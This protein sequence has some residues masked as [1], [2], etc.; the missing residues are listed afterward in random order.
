MKT[1]CFVRFGYLSEDPRLQK[2]VGAALDDGWNVHVVCLKE[3]GRSSL[4]SNERLAVHR[5]KLGR[6]R[7]GKA[8]YLLQYARFL[9]GALARVARIAR[10]QPLAV[11]QVLNVPNL[12]V[13]AALPARRR[14]A[15]IVLDMQEPMPELF[16]DRFGGRAGGVVGAILRGEERL[17]AR[18]A[19]DVITVSDLVRDLVEPRCGRTRPLVVVENTP[20]ERFFQW[21]GEP[22]TPKPFLVSCHSSLLPRYGVNVLVEAFTGLRHLQDVRLEIYGDGEERPEL[23]G[24]ARR[25]GLEDVVTFHGKYPLFELAHD[26]GRVHVGVVPLMRTPFTELMSPNK[27]F[28]YVAL[29]KPVIASRLA[30]MQAYFGEAAVRFVEPGDP[31]QLAGAIEELYGDRALRTSLAREAGLRLESVRWA[32]VRERYLDVLRRS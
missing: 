28:E 8:T 5:L 9:V 15:R 27:L 3:D 23:E 22:E 31:G 4:E 16:V 19:D 30:G 21:V 11:V 6:W 10:R 7:A 24:L 32:V 29:G 18:V 26:L 25:R 12:L 17:G 20:D 14:G 1:I 2:Q 13:L